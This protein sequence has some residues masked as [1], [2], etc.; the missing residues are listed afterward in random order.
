MD[1]L[2]RLPEVES[3]TGLKRSAIYK[4]VGTGEFP[5]PVKITNK[6]VAWPA[7]DI[8]RWIDN[9]LAASRTKAAQP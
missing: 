4:R 9:R 7:S 2:L 5:A 3:R 1:S 6:T 8:S